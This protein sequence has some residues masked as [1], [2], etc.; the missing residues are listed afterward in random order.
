MKLS[1]SV[2]FYRNNVDILHCIILVKVSFEKIKNILGFRAQIGVEEG[3]IEIASSL[4]N[5][6]YRKPYG[7]GLYSNVQM[8]KMIQDEFYTREYRENHLSI[9]LRDFS[10]KD[11]DTSK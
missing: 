8:T 1:T 3:I 11:D 5:G 2:Y 10:R 7:D 4:R 9:L 6:R